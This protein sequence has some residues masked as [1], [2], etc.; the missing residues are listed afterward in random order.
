MKK[1]F[2]NKNLEFYDITDEIQNTIF[3]IWKGYL[4]LDDKAAVESCEYSLKYFKDNQTVVMISDHF[5]LEGATVEFLDWIQ[6]YYFPTSI[7]NGLKAEIVLES[8]DSM[9][10]IALDLMYNKEDMAQ[11]IDTKMLYTPKA[12]SL[13]NAKLLAKKLIGVYNKIN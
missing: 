7:Q 1:I 10:N 2:E 5:N 11:Y 12:D 13:E 4:S 9:A 8:N 6:S 3:A